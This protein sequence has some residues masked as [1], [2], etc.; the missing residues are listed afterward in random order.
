MRYGFIADDEVKA[1]LDNSTKEGGEQI[2]YC[3]LQAP[4]YGVFSLIEWS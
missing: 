1:Q 4:Y 3:L 2:A